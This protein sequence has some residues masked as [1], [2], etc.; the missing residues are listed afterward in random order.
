[1]D[2]VFN[3][4]QQGARGYLVKPFSADRVDSAMI[5]ATKG[6]PFAEAILTARDRNEVFAALIAG[7]LDEYARITRQAESIESARRDLPKGLAALTSATNLAKTFCRDGEA[8]LLETMV[9]FFINLGDGPATKLGRLR[10][11]L[12]KERTDSED[13]ELKS[14]P[15]QKSS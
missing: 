3:L 11:R 8:A 5:Q 6:E 15:S 12:K 7:N 1:M 2:D 9:E 13:V 4:L 10:H 14:F